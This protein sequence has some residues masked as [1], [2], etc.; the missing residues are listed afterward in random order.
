MIAIYKYIL[1]R[2]SHN[3][4]IVNN[5]AEVNGSRATEVVKVHI[6]STEVNVDS[7][8]PLPIWGDCL[9]PSFYYASPLV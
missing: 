8:A 2:I 3:I 7:I 4:G 5:F 9:H 6:A 1:H